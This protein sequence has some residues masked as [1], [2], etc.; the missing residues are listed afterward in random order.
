MGRYLSL[1]EAA[2]R[3]VL[4]GE[5]LWTTRRGGKK[6]NNKEKGPGKAER[7]VRKYSAGSLSAHPSACP[8]FKVKVEAGEGR[9][10]RHE[11]SS[12]TNSFTAEGKQNRR[13]CASRKMRLYWAAGRAR[14]GENHH[15]FQRR[16]CNLART[17]R[18]KRLK[19]A[20]FGAQ[21]PEDARRGDPRSR[22]VPSGA[23]GL[24]RGLGPPGVSLTAALR[25]AGSRVSGRRSLHRS[26]AS[27]PGRTPRP[28]PDA[29]PPVL[30]PRRS[31][32][33]GEARHLTSTRDASGNGDSAAEP[34]RSATARRPHLKHCATASVAL[35][36]CP[37]GPSR[38]L[39]RRT[40]APRY[41]QPSPWLAWSSG[42]LCYAAPSSLAAGH[43]TAQSG[44]EQ[45]RAE[46]SRA[47]QHS[48]R[49]L[50]HR[51]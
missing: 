37:N 47:E 9:R 19:L 39:L 13:R 20:A 22:L 48:A 21:T 30:C 6:E 18:M 35:P 24:W 7:K 42:T 51:A 32:V 46:Q 28:T 40:P 10:T 23:G 33:A 36:S 1:Q 50:A 29:V 8:K 31:R 41:A 12:P 26:R 44:A 45:S 34:A 3:L 2:E 17:T 14:D 16:A 11:Q 25:L 5:I 43:R 49:A 4:R 27:L 38:C 15:S